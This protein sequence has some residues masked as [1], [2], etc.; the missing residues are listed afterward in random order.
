MIVL[1][2]FGLDVTA[3][4]AGYGYMPME[5]MEVC[6]RMGSQIIEQ[7]EQPDFYACVDVAEI[8]AGAEAGS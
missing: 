8:V 5:N 2:I 6:E 1:Y 3:G 7:T 4:I